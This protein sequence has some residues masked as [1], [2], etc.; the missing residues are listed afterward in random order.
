MVLVQFVV[1][2]N[3]QQTN[4]CTWHDV[5]I[6][7]PCSARLLNFMLAHGGNSQHLLQLQSDVFTVPYSSNNFVQC[8]K[9]VL[10]HTTPYSVFDQSHREFHWNNIVIPGRVQWCVY[11]VGAGHY[12]DQDFELILTF[13]IEEL[14]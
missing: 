5:N 4:N 12:F 3:G 6:N 10:I 9:G 2:K 13:D 11:D 7:G 8:S 1:Y 14:P